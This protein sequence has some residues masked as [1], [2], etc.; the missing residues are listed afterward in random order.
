MGVAR[1]ACQVWQGHTSIFTVPFG[2]PVT[3]EFQLVDDAGLEESTT[4]LGLTS[5]LVVDFHVSQ[6][7]HS[8]AYDISAIPTPED[9]VV[10]AF[11]CNPHNRRISSPPPRTFCYRSSPQSTTLS[12]AL[13]GRHPP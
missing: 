2:W 4:E 5:V 1:D 8:V 12:T 13:F 9:S 6:P 10:G 7:G 11:D 3:T